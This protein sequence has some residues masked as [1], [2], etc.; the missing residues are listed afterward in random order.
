MGSSLVATAAVDPYGDV[1]RPWV[2]PGW[3]HVARRM[4]PTHASRAAGSLRQMQTDTYCPPTG[5]TFSGSCGPPA[6]PRDLRLKQSIQG[7]PVLSETPPAF[8]P[9]GGPSRAVRRGGSPAPFR[10]FCPR[11]RAVPCLRRSAS[12]MT[13][14]PVRP[15][16]FLWATTARRGFAPAVLDEPTPACDGERRAVVR[17]AEGPGAELRC[18]VSRWLMASATCSMAVRIVSP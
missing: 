5:D 13:R 18:V 16:E 10:G 2:A 6:P 7:F 12:A 1:R 9:L 11:A 14:R 8:R 4:V 15:A 17:H 3:S